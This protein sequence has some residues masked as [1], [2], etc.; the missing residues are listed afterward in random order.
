[1]SA[2][3]LVCPGACQSEPS[4]NGKDARFAPIGVTS[5]SVE[6]DPAAYTVGDQLE[7]RVDIADR[8]GTT[9][10]CPDSDL[11]CAQNAGSGCIQRL[12]WRVEVR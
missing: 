11:T 6:L 1:M 4:T 12:T 7:L 8:T 5:N 2:P 3:W 9:L 10:T